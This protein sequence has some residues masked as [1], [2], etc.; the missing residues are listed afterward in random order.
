M[1]DTKFNKLII[2]VSLQ[3]FSFCVKNQIT[4]EITFFKSLPINSLASIENQLET[5]FNQNEMLHV[6]YDDILVLHD[7]NLNTFVP[8]VYFN[9]QHLGSYLQ[10]NTKVFATDFFTHDDLELQK[11]KNVYVP[12]VI[13]NNFFIDQFGEFTYKHINTTLLE[14]VLNETKNENNI[15]VHAHINKDHFELIVS[16]KGNL[17]LFNSFEIHTPEDLIY[18]IL[19]SYEQLKLNPEKTAIHLFGTIEK[20]DSNFEI[21]YNYIRNVNISDAKVKIIPFNTETNELQK[22]FILL[23]S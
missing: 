10:Y 22:H 5:I 6:T 17:L 2:Q 23:H 3:N 7:N 20:Y 14:Y 16:Q 1:S 4:D 13:F 12:Y 15:V 21:V 9:E 18:Y 8:D 19:F 11:M